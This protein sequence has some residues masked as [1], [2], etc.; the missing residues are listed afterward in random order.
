M[1]T[2]PDIALKQEKWNCMSDASVSGC[3][4]CLMQQRYGE[5]KVIA[6]GSMT[7]SDTEMRYN[8]TDRELAALRWGINFFRCFLAGVSF[9]LIT[10]HKPLVYLNNMASGNS[11][12]MRTLAE[13]AEFDF[14][15]R[16]RPGVDNE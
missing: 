14:E 15:V 1:L 10:D 8:E 7:F 9:I 5:Y 4:A 13:M 3:G 12:L 11:R 2:Y 6:N 16:Y